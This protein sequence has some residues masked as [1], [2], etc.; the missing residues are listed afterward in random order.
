VED[1]SFVVR[2]GEV[3]GWSEFNGASKTTTLRCL[4]GVIPPAGS[5][6]NLWFDLATRPI[7]PSGTWRSSLTSRGC[8]IISPSNSI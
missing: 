2:P 1:L 8:S 5:G 3:L 6:S 4:Y 7:E